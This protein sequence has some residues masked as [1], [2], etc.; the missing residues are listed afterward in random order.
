M[1][2]IYR[3]QILDYVPPTPQPYRKPRTLN[4]RFRVPGET[5]GE[6][7]PIQ[8]YRKPLALNWRFQVG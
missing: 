1:K 6:N 5:Y 4:W 8:P 2:L 3:A 7:I